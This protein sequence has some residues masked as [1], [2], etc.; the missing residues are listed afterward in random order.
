MKKSVPRPL[1]H[2][3]YTHHPAYA[4]LSA[5]GPPHRS[6]R[7]EA[8]RSSCCRSLDNRVSSS[9]RQKHRGGGAVGGW[10]DQPTINNSPSTSGRSQP[11][12]TVESRSELHTRRWPTVADNAKINS[13]GY[14]FES[15]V[16]AGVALVTSDAHRGLVD[17]IGATLP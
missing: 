7:V 12:P 11:W 4:R 6:V 16:L 1:T 15:T 2:Q 9:R 14:W 5:A 8:V 17:A 3:C 13:Q 10:G